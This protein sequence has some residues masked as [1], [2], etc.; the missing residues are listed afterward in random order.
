[1]RERQWKAGLQ[2]ILIIWFLTG[3]STI[4]IKA[5]GAPQLTSLKFADDN[6]V[7]SQKAWTTYQQGLDKHRQ[8]K[9]LEAVDDLKQAVILSPRFPEAFNMLCVV[10][11]ALSRH[12]EAIR[13]C[14]QAI[15]LKSDF[16]GA[17]YNLGL[18][19]DAT[20]RPTEAIAA[21]R[22]VLALEPRRPEAYYHLGQL[23][24][25]S[26]SYQLAQ[27]SLEQAIGLKPEYAAAYNELGF[28]YCAVGRFEDAIAVFQQAVK[29]APG[30]AH[31]RGN[32]GSAHYF[33]GH[34]AEAIASL[35][36]AIAQQSDLQI[37]QS[38]LG[39]VYLKTS[40]FPEAIDCLRRAINLGSDRSEFQPG[41][42]NDLAA[43]YAHLAKYKKASELLSKAIQLKPDFG[44][45]IFNLGVVDLMSNDRAAAYQ[46]YIT[47]KT[48]DPVLAAKL[49]ARM[50]GPKLIQVKPADRVNE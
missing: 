34:Y 37:V 25:R 39:E 43:A 24:D 41:I 13:S 4:T 22:Q 6:H 28:S 50:V 47:L 44:T 49:Y 8:G 12:D 29:I 2:L 10:Y 7:T 17:F 36:E 16:A 33:A 5:Q 26:H 27:Q 46:Q 40:Q 1:M 32:L 35:S 31:F 20:N 3:L 11:D 23:Y 19:L 21:L 15:A 42:Y 9:D 14:Q 30:E 18:V 38:N 45:A 48:L